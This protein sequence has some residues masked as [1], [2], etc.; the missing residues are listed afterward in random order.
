MEWDGIRMALFFRFFFSF[1]VFLIPHRTVPD[2][3]SFF[4]V[5]GV[6]YLWRGSKGGGPGARLRFGW[7]SSWMDEWDWDERTGGWVDRMDGYSP[8]GW[9]DGCVFALSP[10]FNFLLQTP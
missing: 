6:V 1:F 5:V 7:V 10:F 9:M 8:C 4:L 2:L 3:V